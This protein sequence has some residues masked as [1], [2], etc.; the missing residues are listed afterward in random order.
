MTNVTI[1]IDEKDLKKARI[2]AL[3]QGTSLNAVIRRFL[4]SYIGKVKREQQATKKILQLA[5]TSTFESSGQ[6]IS[7]EQLYER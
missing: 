1:S 4:Q 6:R 3:Q 5:E 7:R 2:L